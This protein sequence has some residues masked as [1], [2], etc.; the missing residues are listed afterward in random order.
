MAASDLFQSVVDSLSAKE[1][2]LVKE[3]I[4][5]WREDL[6]AARSEEARVRLVE[7][8]IRDVH[9]RLMPVKR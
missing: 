2:D 5:M 8:F 4:Q 6:L 3:H 1:R 9:E 7:E